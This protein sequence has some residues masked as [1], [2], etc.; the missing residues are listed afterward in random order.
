MDQLQNYREQIDS[1]D[2]KIQELFLQRMEVVAAIAE[3]KLLR[4]LPVYD[5]GREEAVIQKN[6][7]RI[8]ESPY[9]PYYRPILA[10]ILKES[11][12]FQKAII[13]RST[14]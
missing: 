6:M 3:Y 13:L 5:H 8:K 1:I 10:E 14:L 11:K 4:D 9:A 7:E 12:E 2:Q